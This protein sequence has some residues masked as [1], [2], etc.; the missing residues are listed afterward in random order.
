[1]LE[2]HENLAVSGA[3]STAFLYLSVQVSDIRNKA[4]IYLTVLNQP[5]S[6]LHWQR[7]N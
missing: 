6:D 4:D 1:M 2:N 5:F 7:A 3:I